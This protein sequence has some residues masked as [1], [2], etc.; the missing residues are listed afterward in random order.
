MFLQRNFL[1]K[2]TLNSIF[3]INQVVALLD[4][5]ASVLPFKWVHVCY[6][7]PFQGN[8]WFGL[9]VIKELVYR[10]KPLVK[11]SEVL[12]FDSEEIL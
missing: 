9:Q 11:L 7:Q 2:I 6:F 10:I 12:R 8:K 3:K 5:I 1:K 4:V